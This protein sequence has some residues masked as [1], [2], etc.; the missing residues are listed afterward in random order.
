[1]PYTIDEEKFRKQTSFD[2][3]QPHNT[4]TGIP[5][6]QIPYLEFPRVVY[7]HPKEP[8]RTIEHR[9]AQHEIVQTEMVLAEHLTMLVNDQKELDRAL[10]QGWVK[11]PYIPQAVVDPNAGLYDGK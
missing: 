2:V 4:A 8:F 7:K 6:K 9:N 11:E 3:S 5:V 1:M 10:K